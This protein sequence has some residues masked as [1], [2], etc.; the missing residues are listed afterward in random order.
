MPG[1]IVRGGKGD[2]YE[3]GIR[4]PAVMQW[5]GVI[6]P[7]VVSKVDAAAFDLFSTVLDAASVSAPKHNG[8]FAVQGVSL[9]PHLRSSG[10]TPLPDR[11]LFFDLYGDCGVVHGKWKLGGEIGN[12]GGD[13]RRAASEAE[14]TPFELYNLEDDIAETN[15]LAATQAQIYADLKTRHL[16]WLRQFAGDTGPTR[17]RAETRER[18]RK[19]AKS[20]P[21]KSL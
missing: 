19:K 13:F 8:R 9:L 10:Q 20:A 16:E 12:H 3:G 21:K 18:P 14:K 6:P 1:S 4:V 11:H 17:D 7:G 15:N 5:P 2:T